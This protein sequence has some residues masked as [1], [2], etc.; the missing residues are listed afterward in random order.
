MMRMKTGRE[1]SKKIFQQQKT[2]LSQQRLKMRLVLLEKQR[3]RLERATLMPQR[4]FQALKLRLSQLVIKQRLRR[5]QQ[6]QR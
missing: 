6:G 1:M 4:L 5:V 3:I 2:H